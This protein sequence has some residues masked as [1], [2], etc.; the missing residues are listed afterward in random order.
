M[1]YKKCSFKQNPNI[2]VAELDCE[3]CLFSNESATYYNLNRTSSRIWSYLKE[4]INFDQILEKLLNDFSVI[5]EVCEKE[6]KDF[7]DNGVKLGFVIKT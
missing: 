7:L 5:P 2:V 6:L 4:D 3:Y 1:N